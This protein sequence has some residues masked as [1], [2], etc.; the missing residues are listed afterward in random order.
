MSLDNAIDLNRAKEE[1][2]PYLAIAGNVPPVEVVMNGTKEEIFQ[3]VQECAR[4]GKQMEQGYVLSTGCEIPYGTALS[5][6]DWF[7]EAARQY[8]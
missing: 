7:M 3:S 5:Q 8:G 4:I 6:I 2:S 1:L